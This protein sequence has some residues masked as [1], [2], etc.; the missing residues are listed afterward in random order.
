MLFGAGRRSCTG[1]VFSRTPSNNPAPFND[2]ALS[3]R[4]QTCTALDTARS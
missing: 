4:T 1:Q 2:N 3:G